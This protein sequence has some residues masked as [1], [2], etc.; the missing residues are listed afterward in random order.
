MP[1]GADHDQVGRS[2]ACV[3]GEY[4]FDRAAGTRKLVDCNFDAVSCEISG[5]ISAGSSAVLGLWIDEHQVY[6]SAFC[7]MSSDS[8]AA[9]ADSMVEFHARRTFFG[10]KVTDRRFAASRTGRAE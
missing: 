8:R 2:V 6:P 1:I 7:I 5:D 9:L 3:L 4:L 10:S